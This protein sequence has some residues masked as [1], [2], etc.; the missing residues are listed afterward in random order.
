MTNPLLAPFDAPFGIPPFAAITDADFAPAFDAALAEARSNIAKI[1]DDPAM[2]T[3][4]NVIA[5]LELAETRL[6]RI[7][8]M[9]FSDTE[10]QEIFGV[11]PVGLAELPE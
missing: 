6:D 7:G 9:V 8:G 3:F 4:A 5:A 1:A 2:P 10:Q 11:L